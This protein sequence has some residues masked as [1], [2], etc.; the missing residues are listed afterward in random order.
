MPNYVIWNVDKQVPH[1]CVLKKFV[2][3]S[4]DNTLRHGVP[5][6]NKFP[7]GVAFHMSPDFPTNLLLTDNLRNTDSC[8]VVSAKLAAA[9]RAR[10]VAKMEYL[11]VSIIDHKRKVASK[12]YFILNPLELVDCV[13]RKK[14]KLREDDMVPGDIERIFDLVLDEKRIPKD[15]DVF[16]VKGFAQMT[17][18]SCELADELTAAKFVGLRWVPAEGNPER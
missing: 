7:R 11:P 9:L 1:A 18:A 14:S 8:A 13:D 10:P 12:D 6:E 4:A 2:G 15:R 5:L 17:L 3:F 16:R